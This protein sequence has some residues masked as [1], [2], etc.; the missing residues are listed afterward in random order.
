MDT[1]QNT[2]S[3]DAAGLSLKPII[4]PE[5]AHVLSALSERTSTAVSSYCTSLA[6]H[7]KAERPTQPFVGVKPPVNDG[8]VGQQLVNHAEPCA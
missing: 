1:G 7:T 8:L 6:R 5:L 2:R 3:H 4:D